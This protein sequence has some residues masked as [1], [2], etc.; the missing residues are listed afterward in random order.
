M[1]SRAEAW[2]G[3][4]ERW[5]YLSYAPSTQIWFS[6]IFFYDEVIYGFERERESVGMSRS[7]RGRGREILKPTHCW[8]QSLTL[9]SI[10]GP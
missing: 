7:G 1:S 5:S 10:L 2:E 9:S 6:F 3:S 4:R 8:V